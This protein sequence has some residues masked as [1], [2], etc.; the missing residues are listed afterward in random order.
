MADK[1]D[2]YFYKGYDEKSADYSS[3]GGTSE[4][5]KQSRDNK[6]YAD[7]GSAKKTVRNSILM[8]VSVILGALLTISMFIHIIKNIVPLVNPYLSVIRFAYLA[9]GVGAAAY[10]AVLSF[11][12]AKKQNELSAKN[13]ALAAGTVLASYIVVSLTDIILPPSK[14]LFG[15]LLAV[16]AAFSAYS[17]I[18]MAKNNFRLGT[19]FCAAVFIIL[20]SFVTLKV[21]ITPVYT[22]A[23][24]FNAISLVFTSDESISFADGIHSTVI[25]GMKELDTENEYS[26]VDLMSINSALIGSAEE[27]ENYISSI[28]STDAESI[29]PDKASASI[30]ETLRES[31][32][33]E[34]SRFDE[35]FFRDNDLIIFTDTPVYPNYVV[36][37]FRVGKLYLNFASDL[38]I[39]DV[40]QHYRDL[41]FNT[42]EIYQNDSVCCILVEISKDKTE[43]IRNYVVMTRDVVD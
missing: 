33:E 4:E 31:F 32:K 6:Q 24:D 7:A 40:T 30:A 35:S 23:V 5:N 27:L 34:T 43:S 15:V 13:I 21:F 14:L 18:F 12:S 36:D 9:A 19:G 3:F 42:T 25:P 37:D 26:A 16:C 1:N 10:F 41:N 28:C 11:V 2:G 39:L 38:L 20:S 17:V 29:V 8:L 22:P